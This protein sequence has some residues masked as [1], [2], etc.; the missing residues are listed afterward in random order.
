MTNETNFSDIP[1][2][3]AGN[4]VEEHHDCL[5]L[6][7]LESAAISPVKETPIANAKNLFVDGSRYYTP[8]GK[9]H[10]GYAVTTANGV[11][12]KGSLNSYMSA[13]E[14]E[15]WALAR[16]CELHRGQRN[17]YTDSRYAFGIAHDFGPI[18]K[19]RGFLTSSGKPVKHAELID[20]LFIA[21]N[22]PHEMAILKVRAH[23]SETTLEAM[24]NALADRAAK[25]G[26]LD[27]RGKPLMLAIPS[28]VPLERV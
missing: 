17:V 16:A 27:Q 22:L 23:T 12:E 5:S 24:G 13:Q 15:L 21:F 3:T 19:A 8:D 4:E 1:T 14:A 2:S 10:T 11:V 28:D 20:R 26:A 6:M 18:W 25:E 7:E 9:P